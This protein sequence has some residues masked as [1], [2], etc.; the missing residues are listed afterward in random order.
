MLGKKE[1]TLEFTGFQSEVGLPG[2]AQIRYCIPGNILLIFFLKWI[3]LGE[4][5]KKC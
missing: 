1:S 5:K 2:Q 4:A 3:P